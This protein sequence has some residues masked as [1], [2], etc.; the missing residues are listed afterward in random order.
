MKKHLHLFMILVVALIHSGWSQEQQRIII[1]H[2]GD[3]TKDEEKYPGADIM[4]KD[5]RQV[6]FEHD[7][8]DLWCDVAVFYREQNRVQ[9][10]G[11]VFFQ[12]GD[13]IRMNS[14]YAE[15]DAATRTAVAREDVRLRNNNTT[16]FT[17]KVNFDRNTQIASYDSIGT[18]RDTAN[19]LTSKRGRYYLEKKK[20]EFRDDVV[21]NNPDYNITSARLDYYTNSKN[22]YMY[23]PSTIVGTDYKMY[24]ERGFYSTVTEKGY[25]VKNTRIDYNDRIIYGDSVYFDKTR[26]FASAT[27]NIR[28]IDTINKGLVKGHYAE[29]FKAKDSVFV[30]RRAVA[31]T[32][33]EKDSMY[34]HGD[35]LMVTGPEDQRI[36]RAFRDAR[37]YKSDL[38]G[39]CDSIHSNQQTGITRFIAKIPEGIP[40]NRLGYYRPVLWSGDS[41]MTGDSILLLSD[42]KTEK[43][44]SLKVLNNAFIIQKD[45]T[46]HVTF[47][48]TLKYGFNQIK[49]K[50]L[51]GQFVENQLDN[52]NVVKNAELIYYLW[53]EEGAFMGI[54]KRVCGRIEFTL[55]ENEIDQVTSYNNIDGG[56]YPDKD[57]PVNGRRFRGFHWRGDEMIEGEADLFSKEDDTIQ[58]VPIRGIT[59]P[60]DLDD[61]DPESREFIPGQQREEQEKDSSRASLKTT[62]TRQPKVQKQQ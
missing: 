23:G 58:L 41:Q 27:N 37:F 45:S 52:I 46:S 53:N 1:K 40:E 19:T 18:I 9:A 20:Y 56:I 39:K 29:V 5:N 16:L 31:I 36:V 33:F 13:S 49:G 32:V 55:R 38:S 26:E 21:I 61:P 4:S 12:Q 17:D 54:D 3:F 10:Y 22:V 7:G 2:A 30:T 24:C 47:T 51:Y 59:N 6:Q 62:R 50:D 42:V 60:I 28:V 14:E 43:L 25:G 44:D 35:T 15:Y 8:V 11:N 34:I 57:I 48:D